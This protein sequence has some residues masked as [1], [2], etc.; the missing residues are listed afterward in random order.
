M[1]K[2]IFPSGVLRKL[3][4]FCV[5]CMELWEIWWFVILL[6]VRR[7]DRL[8][9][10]L[11]ARRWLGN[12]G[13]KLPWLCLKIRNLPASLKPT[14]SCIMS[15]LF[16]GR[17]YAQLFLGQEQWLR[18]SGFPFFP[19]FVLSWTNRLP[20][21]FS[22]NSRKGLSR[23]VIFWV[24]SSSSRFR[25]H[26]RERWFM[27]SVDVVVHHGRQETGC[28]ADR[29]R[30]LG[31]VWAQLLLQVKGLNNRYCFNQGATFLVWIIIS[32]I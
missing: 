13:E 6:R 10:Y 2:K 4:G 32:C 15:R 22:H 23:V 28:G 17:L 21:I 3:C 18:Q 27:V 8:L 20:T 16:Y 1:P 7:K 31:Q 29:Q 24:F 12:R 11:W 30:T 14:N 9:S 19:A 25:P 26:S 5:R